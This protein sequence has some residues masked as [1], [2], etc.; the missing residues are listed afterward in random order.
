MSLVLFKASE[1]RFAPGTFPCDHAITTYY[2]P[3]HINMYVMIQ[4]W[5]IVVF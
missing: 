1:F 3:P 2:Q 4:I 5:A